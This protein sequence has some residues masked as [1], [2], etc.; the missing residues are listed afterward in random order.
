[1]TEDNANYT[2]D[3]F[4]IEDD[5]KPEP[6]LAR[7]V[8]HGS[9]TKVSIDTEKCYILWTITLAENGGVMTD[10]ETPVDG[11]TLNYFNYLPKPGDDKEMTASGRNTKRQSKINMLR[12]FSDGLGIT[13]QMKNM[14]TIRE[15]IDNSDFIGIS[16]DAKV[17][18]DTYEGRISNKIDKLIPQT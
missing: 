12:Q 13:E 4:D 2:P 9:V 6:L 8:Y 10:G 3:D 1:M 18:I 16:V 11:A 5:F 15:S 14:A 7:A 17:V